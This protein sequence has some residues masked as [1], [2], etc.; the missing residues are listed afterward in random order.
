MS[1]KRDATFHPDK[2]VKTDGFASGGWSK[3]PLQVPDDEPSRQDYHEQRAATL[4]S[5]AVSGRFPLRTEDQIASAQVHAL[6]AL[7]EAVRHAGR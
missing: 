2:D 5:M 7:A 4:L 3:G 1:K 6:L